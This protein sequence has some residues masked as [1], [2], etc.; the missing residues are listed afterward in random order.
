MAI[1]SFPL[2]ELERLIGR[3]LTKQDLEEYIPMIGVS[4]EGEENG[5]VKFEVFPDR[6]DMFSIEGFAREIR[7]FLGLDEGL[8]SYKVKKSD[9]LFIVDKSVKDVRPYLGSAL[10]RNV[11]LTNETISLLMQLQEKLHETIGRKREK[12]AIGL[13]DFSNIKSP[14]VYK[15]V[16]PNEISFL[17]LDS[18]EEMTLKEILER[19][20]K[21]KHYSW[22]LRHSSKYPVIVDANNNIISFPPIINAELTRVTENTKNILLDVTGKDARVVEHVVN[23]ICSSFA[24]RG[25]E[26]CSVMI[27]NKLMPEMKNKKINVSV[28]YVNKL[29][30]LKLSK[31][32]ISKLLKKMGMEMKNNIVVIPCYRV[33]IMHPIDIVEDIAISYGYKNFEPRIC[34]AMTIAKRLEKEEFYNFIREFMISLQLQEVVTMILTNKDNLFRKMCRDYVDVVETLNPVSKECSVV[35]DMLIP[36]LLKVLFENKHNDY[37]QKIF[38]IGDIVKITDNGFKEEKHLAVCITHDNANYN[39]VSDIVYTL[40]NALN[41]KCRLQEVCNKS[42]IKHRVAEISIRNEILG[43]LGEVNPQVLENFGLEKP[44]VVCEINIDKLKIHC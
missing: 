22:I 32:E 14:F 38:E 25:C 21:G 10:I 34:A 15:A 30:G 3:K 39:E 44:V 17:A 26:I 35:R 6:I 37:P 7:K 40:F 24:E 33:D 36:S 2:H 42:F 43:I 19:H 20:E 4:F 31:T 5:E 28:D 11:N 8:S 18:K 41:L 1:V 12:V 13:H 16:S 29:L 9:V 23:I 27:N